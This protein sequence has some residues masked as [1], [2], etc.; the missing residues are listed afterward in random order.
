MSSIEDSL[1]VF[2]VLTR[3][4]TDELRRIH[5]RMPLIFPKERIDE[6]IDPRSNPEELL[7]FEMTDMVVEKAI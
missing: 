7:R 4:P 6:W 5:D 3:E 2:T 1:P